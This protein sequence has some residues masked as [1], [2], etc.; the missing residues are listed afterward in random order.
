MTLHSAS[1]G[2]GSATDLFLSKFHPFSSVYPC[3]KSVC[4]RIKEKAVVVYLVY[5]LYEYPSISALTISD[6]VI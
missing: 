1:L 6:L 4:G 5:G 2:F 3:E